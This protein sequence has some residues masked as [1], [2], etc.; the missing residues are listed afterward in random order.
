MNTGELPTW[1]TPREAARVVLHRPHLAQTSVTALIVG[2]ILFAI[3][4]LDTVLRGQATTETWIKIGIT[5]L[6]PF[7][8]ANVGVLFGSRRRSP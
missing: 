6:V 3:N 8:V 1:R 7:I 5:Y 4:H 2:S